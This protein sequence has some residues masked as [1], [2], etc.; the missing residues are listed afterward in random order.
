MSLALM[1]GV[2]FVKSHSKHPQDIKNRFWFTAHKDL[3]YF[4]TN[5]LNPEIDI[6]SCFCPG[7]IKWFKKCQKKSWDYDV[8]V[9]ELAWQFRSQKIP[10]FY[11]SISS[12]ILK[13]KKMVGLEWKGH[14]HFIPYS[15]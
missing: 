7:N 12:S 4:C 15:T 3:F 2:G 9:I 6:M 14:G 11:L 5:K 13:K 10:T 8:N 1:Y